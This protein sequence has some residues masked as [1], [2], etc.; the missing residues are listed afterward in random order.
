M[1]DTSR[2]LAPAPKRTEKRI[3][4][5]EHA[6][7]IKAIHARAADLM[8]ADYLITHQQA[9]PERG[10]KMRALAR[11]RTLIRNA[12]R[13]ANAKRSCPVM[14]TIHLHGEEPIPVDTTQ[15]AAPAVE[16]VL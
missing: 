7:N 1:I 9:E 6:Q 16:R 15:E 12:K 8:P 2:Q 3:L 11:Q 5:D 14:I 4:K 13:L 10:F